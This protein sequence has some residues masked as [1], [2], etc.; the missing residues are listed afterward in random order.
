[1]DH[2]LPP[3]RKNE[4]ARRDFVRIAVHEVAHALIHGL[5][6]C[7]GLWIWPTPGGVTLDRNSFTGQC[8]LSIQASPE[9]S[10]AG[11]LAVFLH[12][13]FC[14][15][16]GSGGDWPDGF[17][18]WTE[19]FCELFAALSENGSVSETDLSGIGQLSYDEFAGL[20][21]KVSAELRNLWPDLLRI[22]GVLVDQF[23]ED[24]SN[25]CYGFTDWMLRELR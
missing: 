13:T 10:V 6:S 17:S 9:T 25:D 5:S 16:F 18:F 11:E 22:V 23:E 2:S 3:N 19:E 15:E 14:E 21:E 7:Q 4:I 12:S 1:M 20:A 24:P 8:L